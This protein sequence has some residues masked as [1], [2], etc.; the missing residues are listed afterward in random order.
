MKLLPK[1]ILLFALLFLVTV[2]PAQAGDYFLTIGGGYAPTGNQISLEKNVQL[3]QQ[4]VQE[5]FPNKA[6]HTVLFSDG[7]GPGRDLQYRDPNLI[8]PPVNQTLA[9]IFGQGERPGLPV[10]KSPSQ[11]CLGKCQSQEHPAV[12]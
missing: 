3:F 6:S 11:R 10:S 7:K 9:Q 2:V 1:G 5:Q 12:V 4:L 8:I